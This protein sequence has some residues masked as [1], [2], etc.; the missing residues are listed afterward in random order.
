VTTRVPPLLKSLLV[1]LI[2]A[3]ASL[4]SASP[5]A[6][7]PP[8]K[9]CNVWRMVDQPDRSNRVYGAGGFICERRQAGTVRVGIYRNGRHIVTTSAQ[10]EN[11][12]YYHC[13]DLNSRCAASTRPI[14]NPRGKQ[15][16]CVRVH[17]HWGGTNTVR[18]RCRF[19]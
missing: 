1:I 3:S 8:P 10:D 4:V 13:N 19:L 9:G 12:G 17:V 16:F 2:G 15:D 7:V 5:A 18:W 11:G 6:A 14:R